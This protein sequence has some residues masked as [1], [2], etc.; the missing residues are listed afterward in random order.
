MGALMRS[1][2]LLAALD[3]VDEYLLPRILEALNWIGDASPHVEVLLKH[4]NQEVNDNALLIFAQKADRE[5]AVQQLIRGL[6]S[7]SRWMQ[8]RCAEIIA[9]LQ[10][11]E[12][13]PYLRE[14]ALWSDDFTPHMAGRSAC[15][16]PGKLGAS[17][18]D[19]LLEATYHTDGRI[20]ANAKNLSRDFTKLSPSRLPQIFMDVL[21]CDTACANR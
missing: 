10:A 1:P 11:E 19:F 6:Q 17:Q 8:E 2:H 21:D 4:P 20:Q 3:Q 9:P 18:L 7:P 16:A 5:Q 15:I 14:I 12:A 13:A